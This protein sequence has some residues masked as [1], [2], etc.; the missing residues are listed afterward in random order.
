MMIDELYVEQTLHGYSN[1][2]RL[3]Q[4]SF[5][6]SEQDSKKMMTLS[7]LSGNEFVNGFER[8]F[9]GYSLNDERIVLACTWYAEEMKRPGC[10]WTHSLI[11][12]VHDFLLMR[13]DV[14]SI[15]KIFKRPNI[16]SDFASYSNSL[17]FVRESHDQL[18]DNNLKYLLW[19]IWGN[20]NPLIIFN[21]KSTGLEKEIIFLFLTQHDLLEEDYSFCTGSVAL[22]GYG[23]KTLQLQI[24]P[25][26]IS[27]S[28]LYIGEKTYEA[29][30]KNIIKNYPFWVNKMFD[31]LKKDN[32][33]KY[34]KFVAG[35][36]KEYKQPVYVPAFMKLYVG[37]CADKKRASLVTLLQMSSAIFEDEKK[38]CNE[39]L[40]LY[41]K[42]YFSCWCEK[43]NYNEV[44]EYFVNNI[45][46]DISLIDIRKMVNE[47]YIADYGGAQRLVK[48]IIKREESTI[49]ELL[50]KEYADLISENQ[51][52]DFTGLEYDCCSALISIKN[53]FA[54]CQEIWK[55]SK[56]Y[57]Q[58]IIRCLSR[59]EEIVD[60]KIIQTVL[61]TSVYDLS[62][63]LY[64]VYEK[65]CMQEFWDYLLDNLDNLE[66]EKVKGIINIVSEDIESEV[67][68][69][70]CNITERDTL[71]FLVSMVNP[72]NREIQ[73]LSKEDVYR[74]YK[75]IMGENCSENEKEILA[76]FLL[77]ICIL[78]DY[79]LDTEIARFSFE[80]VNEMLAT[81]NFPEI[82]WDKLEKILPEVAFYNN[83]DRC[84]RLRKGF[85]KRGYS[86]IGES[87]EA[88][89]TYLP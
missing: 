87:E 79:M 69:I 51:F 20:R 40:T 55:R 24:V 64:R 31:N 39:I 37:S 80:I 74:I 48:N 18:D 23:G 68:L 82:E 8:Y 9:T 63:D 53:E 12:N 88:L 81:Q 41:S 66:N 28:K 7:D 61:Q 58:G 5:K 73:R 46:L 83:W 54:F 57:Q 43:E 85:R 22:R 4:A 33:K 50:L 52:A 11:F 21:D 10:V 19:C 45:W 56:G 2:H 44:L 15:I 16:E 67:K 70:L 14:A 84:K 30:D 29:K 77:P 42:N 89:P 38:I 72:Y 34:R 49:I 62:Y 76:K 78:A 3:L 36:S 25:R 59:K 1:G 65:E 26:K 17:K 86:F 13:E 75:T 60:K 47:G 32:L 27:R 71:L 6:L 35:F